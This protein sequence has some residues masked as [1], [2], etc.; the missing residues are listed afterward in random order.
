MELPPTRKLALVVE[1]DGTGY[2]GFQVQVGEPTIQGEIE[3]ALNK[4]TG[5]RI[6]VAG[7]GRTDAGVHAKGQ[8]VSFSCAFNLSL[9]TVIRALNFHLPSDIAVKAGSE[10]DKNFNARRD[11]LSREYRY[12]IL[13]S[14]TPSPLQRRYAYH[15]P[16]PLDIDAMNEA[17]GFLLGMHDFASFTSPMGGRRTVRTVFKAEVS[18]QGELVFF[19]MVA[20]SFLHKQVRS[21]AGC[22]LRVGL[23]KITVEEFKGILE[24]KKPGMAAPV[25]PALG[26]C[27]V[28]VNYPEHKLG[29]GQFYENL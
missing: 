17:C 12:T 3:R 21:T 10:V 22:L 28:K 7:A 2:H 15:V 20:D 11:A 29:K 26:L 18:R 27:L 25:A 8:V 1:Y 24:A 14:A 4:L 5:E 6:R 16:L 13:N 19:D 9:D 23:G